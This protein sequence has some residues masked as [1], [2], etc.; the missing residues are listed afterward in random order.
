M[1]ARRRRDRSPRSETSA[2]LFGPCEGSRSWRCSISVELYGRV[3]HYAPF[4]SAVP[5]HR[6]GQSA[7][8]AA[9]SKGDK[10]LRN[11]WIALWYIVRHAACSL[12]AGFAAV[13]CQH[14]QVRQCRGADHATNTD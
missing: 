12:S 6:F 10:N 8:K 2:L 7:A 11:L 14:H 9:H 4:W 3:F 1:I 13:H 5:W